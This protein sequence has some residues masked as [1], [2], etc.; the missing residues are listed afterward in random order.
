MK[1][2]FII[3]KDIS[4]YDNIPIHIQGKNSEL[5]SILSSVGMDSLTSPTYSSELNLIELAF[6]ILV[7]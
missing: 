7:Q 2:G 6:N 3:Q 1:I 5:Q 4:I